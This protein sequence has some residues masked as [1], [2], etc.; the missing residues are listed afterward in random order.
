MNISTKIWMLDV[1]GDYIKQRE[2]DIAVSLIPAVLGMIGV[3]VI[4]L[5]IALKNQRYKKFI[6]Y[7]KLEKEFVEYQAIQK[8]L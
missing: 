4:F 3:T 7:K 1:C 8:K 2:H 5:I 6:E